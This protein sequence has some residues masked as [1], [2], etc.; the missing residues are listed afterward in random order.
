MSTSGYSGI[1][2]I[3]IVKNG[4]KQGSV[5]GSYEIN[6]PQIKMF[7]I[8][9]CVVIILYLIFSIVSSGIA[10]KAFDDNKDKINQNEFKY[11]I[12]KMHLITSSILLGIVMLF[13]GLFIYKTNHIKLF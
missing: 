5:E 1:N 4:L 8:T 13:L 7:I 3:K 10:Q 12:V 2:P 9:A 6:L 11:K